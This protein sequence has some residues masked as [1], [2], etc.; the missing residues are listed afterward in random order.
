MYCTFAV[1]KKCSCKS[2]SKI[3]STF[4]SVKR[5]LARYLQRERER[6]EENTFIH[7]LY[8]RTRVYIKFFQNMIKPSALFYNLCGN[9]CISPTNYFPINN[10]F[11]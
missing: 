4:P 9:F 8:M 5:R 10:E 6:L 3:I 7:Y 1:Q 11:N 2:F